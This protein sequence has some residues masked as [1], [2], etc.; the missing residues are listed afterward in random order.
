MNILF[1]E[2]RL[3]KLIANLNILTGVPAN[4][5]DLS[6][7]DI[8]LFRGHPPFC[9]M[10]NDLPEGHRRCVACDQCK[11]RRY[12]AESG[13]QHYRC[14]VGICEAVMPLYNKQNPVAYLAVGCYLDD[15]PIEE[16]W[17]YTRSLLDW[18]P[19][20]PD[21]LK[22]AFFQF[23]RY[24]KAEIQAYTETLEALSA[25]IQLKG[26]ILT[27]E[28]TDL[29]KLELYLDQHYMEKLSLESI[30]QQLHIGRTKLCSLAKELSGGHTLS[31]LISQR[32]IEAA[33]RLLLQS[34][35]P[36]SAVG[37][38]VGVSDYN[39]FSKVFRSAT[40]MTPSAFRKNCRDAAAGAASNFS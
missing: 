20:G 9:R 29:Q 26:M 19:D 22:D 34:S 3:R 38:T 40:G 10:I 15:S 30:S 35:M 13:F 31:Y 32:R 8:N 25:Y 23:R 7:R 21:S 28:Q 12:E 6:G 2:E 17:E 18:W 4:I 16:Q 33:K 36:I 39:Y 37:E 11:I 24:S 14:H 5:L 1:D 27:A